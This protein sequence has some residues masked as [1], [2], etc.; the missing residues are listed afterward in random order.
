M[1]KIFKEKYSPQL[2]PYHIIV[3]SLP[4]F[5]FS[6]KPPVYKDWGIEHSGRLLHGLMV[7]LGFGGGYTV[8]GTDIGT[9][10]ARYMVAKYE[11]CKGKLL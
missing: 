5:A 10:A 3:P 11:A 2:L 9:F 4:G 1:L 6:S 7:G 8:Q